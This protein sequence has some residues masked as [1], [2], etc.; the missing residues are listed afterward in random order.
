[1]RLPPRLTAALSLAVVAAAVPAQKPAWQAPA[2]PQHDGDVLALAWSP[3]GRLLASGG[4]E[5]A[6]KVWDART[7]AL[8]HRCQGHR[9][10]VS[11]LAWSP[12]GALLASGS[13]DTLV[14]LWSPR[15][16]QLVRELRGHEA[17]VLAVAF[18]GDGQRLA[19]ASYDET[20]RLWDVASGREVRRFSGHED[21]VSGV[22]LSP[23]GGTLVT[24]GFDGS[25][26]TWAAASG[27][28]RNL[29]RLGKRTEATGLAYLRRGD[30]VAACTGRGDLFR[31]APEGDD[32]DRM[33]AGAALLA[34]AVSADGRTLAVGTAEGS[35]SLFETPAFRPVLTFDGREAAPPLPTF[36]VVGPSGPGDVRAVA[37]APAGGRVAVGMRTG[38]IAVYSVG[39]LL[40]KGERLGPPEADE[41]PALWRAL[42]DD[43]GA[44]GYLA[45]ARLAA[46]PGRS[47][48][49]LRDRLR[50]PAPADPARTRALIDKLADDD[51]EARETATAALE[52]IL[53]QAEGALREA[54]KRAGDLEARRRAAQ[55]LAKLEGQP[56]LGDRLRQG[57]ALMALEQAGEPARALLGELAK[58]PGGGL[59]AEEA[60]AVLAR[61]RGG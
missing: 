48:P 55:L 46:A 43:D 5:G 7:G 33:T 60:A 1:M 35:V 59:L 10:R 20:A 34:L 61:L 53:P 28:R 30:R 16:G 13:G 15:T 12:D 49:F 37:L 58:A 50:P 54:V 52:E 6:V 11:A 38:R 40:A 17:W 8:L 31:A 18:S 57:R 24:V 26:R 45:A 47:L 41:L 25:L 9:G 21:A 3:D 14:R 2:A 39:G 56:F 22:A 29:L 36:A 44:A 27:Q 51:F 42:G 4:V 32:L 19:S 23:D